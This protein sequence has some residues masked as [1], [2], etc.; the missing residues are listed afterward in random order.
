[1]GTKT[2]QA[3]WL[4]PFLP[5]GLMKSI[6][7]VRSLTLSADGIVVGVGYTLM[8]KVEGVEFRQRYKNLRSQYFEFRNQV[9]ALERA[10]VSRRFSQIGSSVTKRTPSKA[11]YGLYA[12]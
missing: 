6:R 7:H 8:E 2:K 11:K 9:N 5:Q 10:F 1:M 3:F 4:L 12:E